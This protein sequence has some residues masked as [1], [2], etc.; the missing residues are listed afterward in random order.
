MLLKAHMPRCWASVEEV[1][2]RKSWRCLVAI[3]DR[4]D[5]GVANTVFSNAADLGRR[6]AVS[7]ILFRFLG[8]RIYPRCFPL[9]PSFK[10]AIATRAFEEQ[11]LEDASSSQTCKNDLG[12]LWEDPQ[13]PIAGR[14]VT[15]L[16]G[17]LTIQNVLTRKHVTFEAQST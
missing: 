16:F 1:R 13:Y 5:C 17:P 3:S 12:Q 14:S 4:R 6:S 11:T 10:S 9:L 7:S 15:S 2:G 8:S